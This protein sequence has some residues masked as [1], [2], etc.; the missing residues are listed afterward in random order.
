VENVLE[1]TFYRDFPCLNYL[2]PN[3]LCCSFW[4][5]HAVRKSSP[6]K[7]TQDKRIVLLLS[8]ALFCLGAGYETT[9]SGINKRS[10]PNTTKQR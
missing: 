6:L 3:L 10:T 4:A 5:V 9:K 2:H 1:M 7:V 8:A